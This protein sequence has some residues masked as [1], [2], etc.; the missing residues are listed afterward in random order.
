MW[1][2][3]Q[4]VGTIREFID[5][6]AA[7]VPLAATKHE[8]VLTTLTHFLSN[9]TQALGDSAFNAINPFLEIAGIISYPVASII[10][11]VAGLMYIIGF[12]EKCVSWMTKTTITYIIVQLLP[13]LLRT[14]INSIIAA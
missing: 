8:G 2:K 7:I 6:N 1:H 9:P 4:T 12:R 13:L 10:M 11:V 3:I 14:A 5:T